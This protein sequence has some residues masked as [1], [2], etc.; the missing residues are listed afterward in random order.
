MLNPVCSHHTNVNT[1]E[2]N[3]SR[4]Q[5]EVETT[6]YLQNLKAQ[7]NSLFLSVKS[8]FA[9]SHVGCF[10]LLLLYCV[11]FI[12]QFLRWWSTIIHQSSVRLIQVYMASACAML[13]QNIFGAVFSW[14][15]G[16]E[17]TKIKREKSL[18]F[19][20]RCLSVRER[21]EMML[22]VWKLYGKMWKIHV[23]TDNQQ[24]KKQC[25]FVQL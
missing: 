25:C 13:F 9:C 12:T 21:E 3:T 2:S 1:S 19:S 18:D 4:Q 15:I 20:E 11:L 17:P 5:V 10:L 7:L 14:W 23:T 22:A 6:R 24:E 16:L 8:L